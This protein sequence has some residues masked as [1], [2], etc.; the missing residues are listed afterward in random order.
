MDDNISCERPKTVHKSIPES[1]PGLRP[2][3]LHNK[4]PETSCL[5][6]HDPTQRANG[7]MTL[8][9]GIVITFAKEILNLITGG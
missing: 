7:I 1:H 4:C 9:G 3:H 6:S 5:K 2:T 8:A